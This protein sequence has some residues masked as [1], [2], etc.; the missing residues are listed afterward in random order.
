ML[1]LTLYILFLIGK[2]V[3]LASAPLSILIQEDPSSMDWLG[4]DVNWHKNMAHLSPK[5]KSP[6]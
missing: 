6:L 4:I 2:A 1:D 3:I 5:V